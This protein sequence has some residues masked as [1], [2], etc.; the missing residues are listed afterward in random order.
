MYMTLEEVKAL[1]GSTVSTNIVAA[2]T[3]SSA[4]T[5]RNTCKKGRDCFGIS[6]I[7]SGNRIKFSKASLVKFLEGGNL[8]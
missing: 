4:T 1:P 8:S 3:G 6:F 5:I 7:C 2:A